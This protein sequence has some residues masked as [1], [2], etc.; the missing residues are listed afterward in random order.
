DQRGR[1]DARTL[2]EAERPARRPRLQLRRAELLRE[3]LEPRDREERLRRRRQQTEAVDQLDLQ[4]I[5]LVLRRRVRDP[6][7]VHE[8]RVHVWHVVLG[9]QRGQAELDLRAV[10]E[11][12]L[13]I[14]LPAFLQLLDRACE[15]LVVER[16][17]DRLDLS[18]LTL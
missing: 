18:A 8:A 1:I 10:R 11:R 4:L 12:I 7:V 17:A 14:W 15:Q 6:L 16:E 3:E 9:N 13:E 5:E 2:A